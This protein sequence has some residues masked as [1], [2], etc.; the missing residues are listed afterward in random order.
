MN[1]N[2]KEV[3]FLCNYFQSNLTSPINGK[4]NFS[5][6]ICP[7][8][9]VADLICINNIWQIN[10]TSNNI[11]KRQ[12]NPPMRH[13]DI[14][15]TKINQNDNYI[16]VILESPHYDEYDQFSHAPYGPACK[17]SGYYFLKHFVNII[18]RNNTIMSKL[19]KRTYKIIFINSVQYQTSLGYKPLKKKIRDR[20]WLNLWGWA[21]NTDL[22]N[23][24]KSFPTKNSIIINLCTIGCNNLRN[25][26]SNQLNM[27]NIVHHY[28]YHPCTWFNPK[29]R[30]I[31]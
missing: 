26:V 24:I 1:Y 7:D 8:Q 9:Y 27:H 3:N 6:Q 18:L 20:N 25:M 13:L 16:L 10:Q 4:Y 28:G 14:D 15:Y 2:N 23:R 21:F 30:Q 19:T 12:V 29:K 22:I 31:I 17:T 5:S 11:L